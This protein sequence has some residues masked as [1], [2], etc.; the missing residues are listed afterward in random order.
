[1]F[2]P[3]YF[4]LIVKE[5]DDLL[6]DRLAIK[7]KEYAEKL[8]EEQKEPTRIGTEKGSKKEET[9]QDVGSQLIKAVWEGRYED[10]REEH[11]DFLRASSSSAL[12][13]KVG[14]ALLGPYWNIVLTRMD[15]KTILERFSGEDKTQ[16]FGDTPDKKE[17][18]ESPLSV[19]EG[20]DHYK[21][22]KIQPVEYCHANNLGICES[23]IIKYVTRYKD[24][25]GKEDLKKARHF[26]D[27]LIHLEY[28]S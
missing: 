12:W 13:C 21:K 14:E 28:G 1:M 3:D 16:D 18:T 2:N 4:Q 23:N 15:N 10:L 7:L 27:L 26:L 17:E 11:L 6:Y 5:T 22:L 20:G 19:Q 25:N 8:K 24:K 9:K